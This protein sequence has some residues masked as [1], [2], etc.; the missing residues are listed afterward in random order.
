MKQ[1]SRLRASYILFDYLTINVGWLIFNIVRYISLP[2]EW[3]M[4]TL[5]SW[6]F[7]F[8]P[9]VL[10]QF[11]IPIMMVILYAISGFY[12]Y[13]SEKSRLTEA[14]NT[15][16][17]SLIGTLIIFFAVLIN[18]SVPERVRNYELILILWLLMFL[19][20]YIS[21][22]LITMRQRRR[23]KDGTG[24]Y[25]A[26]VI[27]PASAVHTM[28]RK[29]S[30]AGKIRQFN[31][32]GTVTTDSYN[33]RT[34]LQSFNIN[35]LEQAINDLQPQ[36]L[37]LAEGSMN[38]SQKLDLITKLF[39]TGIDIYVPVD[40]Y[41]TITSRPKISS[42]TNEPL[43]N[44]SRP[45]ISE[46]TIN[47][48]RIGDVVVSAITLILLTPIFAVVAI[49][50]R[51]DSPGPIFYRQERVGYRK[52]IFKII[53]FRTMYCNAEANGPTLSTV[54][55]P[56]V[57]RVGKFLRKYRIDEFPQ[58]WNV[59]R[60]EMSIVGPRPEREYYINKI[61]ERVPHYSLVHQV[62]PGIT[63]WGMVKFGYA[64]NVDEMI[65]RLNY[66][67]LY[68]DNVSFGVDLKILCYTVN[69]VITGKGV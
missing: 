1:E 51:R 53:K 10:G 67:L 12:N 21:R 66:D 4:I 17:I 49:A 33:D 20:C 24:L 41:R 54:D 45:N 36:V 22:V 26:I 8:P 44:I 42:L 55:D 65:E 18:D 14:G 35:Q 5:D 38:L 25:T 40:L 23:L 60:G 69:T 31:I 13:V 56:R 34:N 15:A 43:I 16:F 28:V 7:T 50:I 62:R 68:L 39:R 2:Q 9:V 52:R 29:L 63:S 59:L 61:V 27:G 11:F 30:P 64:G 19:P 47:L 48:K 3:K 57:T 32:I 46:A 6:L 37:I 58:F